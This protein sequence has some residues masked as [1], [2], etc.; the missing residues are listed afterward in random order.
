MYAGGSQGTRP[1]TVSLAGLSVE[2]PSGPLSGGHLRAWGPVS[3]LPGRAHRYGH[4]GPGLAGGDPRPY[5]LL[6]GYSRAL[7]PPS[8]T[9]ITPRSDNGVI[10]G[11]RPGSRAY[12]G[13]LAV[14]GAFASLSAFG[15]LDCE[16]RCPLRAHVEADA[17][18]PHRRLL[19]P[20]LPSAD[21]RRSYVPERVGGGRG[22]RRSVRHT[23]TPTHD[24]IEP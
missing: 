14:Q 12:G 1:I 24:H 6:R 22:C 20:V 7:S 4:C 18:R 5:G 8:V 10:I 16:P 3:K 17:M 21:D 11:D 23:P 19:A 9:I 15:A 2:V 13:T